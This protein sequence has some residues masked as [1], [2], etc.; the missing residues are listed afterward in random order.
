M[1]VDSLKI[2]ENSDGTF[3][4]EWDK[5]D[6]EWSWMNSLT[7]REIKSIVE[8]AIKEYGNDEK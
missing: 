8:T 4:I 6:P 3:S 5:N 1:K 2:S 7:S